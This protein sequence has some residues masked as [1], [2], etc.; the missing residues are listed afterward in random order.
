MS[1]NHISYLLGSIDAWFQQMDEQNRNCA[2]SCVGNRR[3]KT[4]RRAYEKMYRAQS[5]TSEIPSLTGKD[6]SVLRARSPPMNVEHA[7]LDLAKCFDW[8]HVRERL[9]TEPALVKMAADST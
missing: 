2:D 7:F 1:R 5:S 9:R 4:F 3:R 6:E 8:D